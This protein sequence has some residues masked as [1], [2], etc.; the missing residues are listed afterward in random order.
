VQHGGGG[1]AG[2]VDDLGP[3]VRFPDDVQLAVLVQLASLQASWRCQSPSSLIFSPFFFVF[4]LQRGEN[5]TQ[6]YDGSGE[7]FSI[8]IQRSGWHGFNAA[9]LARC[10]FLIHT[11]PDPCCDVQTLLL[12][13]RTGRPCMQ[14]VSGGAHAHAR[15]GDGG[16]GD[17]RGDRRGVWSTTKKQKLKELQDDRTVKMG[18]WWT[19][20]SRPSVSTLAP[21]ASASAT[22]FSTSRPTACKPCFDSYCIALHPIASK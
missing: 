21:L 12:A 1:Q 2:A 11:Q 8:R 4:Y 3:Q 7:K 19:W 18:G 22:A 14:K 20:F 10:D 17:A 5:L 16:A 9:C 15:H 6:S 13:A